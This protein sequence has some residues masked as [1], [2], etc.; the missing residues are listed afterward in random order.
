MAR[1]RRPLPR[2][3]LLF[4][5]VIACIGGDQARAADDPSEQVLK[6]NQLRMVGSLAIADTEA[7]IKSKLTEARRTAQ[8]LRSLQIQ[9]SSTMSAEERQK[10]I[11]SL[12]DQ[13]GQLRNELNAVTQQMNQ[14]PRMRG[15]MVNNYAQAQFTELQAYRA[16]I[17]VELSQEA[18]VLSQLKSPSADPKAKEKLDADIR[19]KTEAYHQALL[20]LRKLVDETSQ[21]YSELGQNEEVSKALQTLSK[22]RKD[23]LKLGPSHDFTA[24]VRLLEKLE[25]AAAQGDT[26]ETATKSTRRSKRAS[27]AKRAAGS[28]E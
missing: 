21:K 18:A 6:K 26:E 3:V 15:R 17:Q 7:P 13:I 22:G 1:F 16:S 19:D 28:E 27:K 12:N 24:N 4:A 23:K 25:K 20:D 11:G 2:I 14:I 10:A 9:Q 8:R 5:T